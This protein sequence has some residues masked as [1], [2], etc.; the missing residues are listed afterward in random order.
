MSVRDG[1]DGA[2]AETATPLLKPGEPVDVTNCDRE[3]IHIPGRIQPYGVL[4]ALDGRGGDL[5][6]TQ[7]SDNAAEVFGAESAT[8]LIGTTLEAVLGPD[9]A[10]RLREALL[11]PDAEVE[12]R[13]AYLFPLDVRGQRFDAAAHRAPGGELVLELEPVVAGGSDAAAPPAQ[14]PDYYALVRKAMPRFHRAR[15]IA[16]LGDAVVDE[17]RRVSGFDRVMLY[18]FDAD[19]HGSV[20][21][22][23]R[24]DDLPPFLGLHYPAS[25]IP[26]QARRLYLLNPLRIIADVAHAPAALVPPLSPVTGAPLDMS[27]CVLRSPSPIHIEYLKNMGVG[28][29]LTISVIDGGALWGLIACHHETPRVVPFDVRAA[30]E[31]LGQVTG[32]QLAGKQDGE[33]MAYRSRLQ[34]AEARLVEEMSRAERYQNALS[35]TSGG[36][37]DLRD[38]VDAGGAAV[39]VDGECA[40]LG[41][42]PPEGFIRRL[43]AWLSESVPEDVW[44]TDALADHFPEASGHADVAS[45]VLA[46]SVTRGGPDNYLLWF[47][48]EVVQTVDWAGDPNKA[49]T[50]VAADGSPR[51]SPRGSFALWKETVRGRS[52]PWRAVER[53]A[54]RSL[55]RASVEVVLKKAE[56]VA[57]LNTVLARS[58]RELDDFAYIASHDLKEP[59]RGI[60]NYA[61]FL[62]EDYAD[63]LD[64]EGRARLETLG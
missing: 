44:A 59:L 64:D 26:Q 32:L 47:R 9:Q 14:S 5:A 28:A 35:G 6:V 16:E 10:R 19:G 49:V 41:A 53:D 58:N 61:H 55:R 24:R 3:P 29:T 20:V 37:T 22:E 4:L 23:S 40:R 11:R 18:R 57:H 50:A 15:T 25:D 12:E 46:L 36:G 30:C 48:P 62:H 45:G 13:P 43:V 60:Q 7:V 1:G 63:V 51:L 56:Q 54:A 27:Y 8:S 17:V 33:D 31:F 42:A 38:F 2:A 21:S 34:G 39:F 52:L